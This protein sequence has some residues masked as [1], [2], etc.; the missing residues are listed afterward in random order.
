MAKRI[1]VTT[2]PLPFDA[3]TPKLDIGA[4]GWMTTMP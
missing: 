3:S 1:M 4:T 2:W